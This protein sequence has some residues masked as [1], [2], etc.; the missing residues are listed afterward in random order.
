MMRG[1]APQIFFSL[2]RHW[3]LELLGHAV[4][5][6]AYSTTSSW[7]FLLL[8]PCTPAV[9]GWVESIL[10]GISRSTELYMPT[11]RPSVDVCRMINWRQRT[12]IMRRLKLQSK[13]SQCWELT[14]RNSVTILTFTGWLQ[15]RSRPTVCIT[16]YPILAS[17]K[18][19]LR[20]SCSEL[21]REF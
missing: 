9:T 18:H 14:D 19:R 21:L 15:V 13:T 3:W 17:E 12:C 4:S 16:L 7:H 5:V 10:L 8:T 1:Q 6:Q 20:L 2:N 11:I